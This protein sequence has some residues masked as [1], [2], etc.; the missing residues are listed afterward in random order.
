MVPM[1]DGA[2][3]A[4]AIYFP[5]KDGVRPEGKLP[6]ILERTPYN[7]DAK[8]N[9]GEALICSDSRGPSRTL[10]PP[11]HALGVPAFSWPHTKA[12]ESLRKHRVRRLLAVELGSLGWGGML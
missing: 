11:P 5:A 1:R 12:A 8:P 7:F 3:L 2:R 10:E 6:A 9:T 4:T